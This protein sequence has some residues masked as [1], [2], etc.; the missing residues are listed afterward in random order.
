MV[1]REANE[2]KGGAEWSLHDNVIA[3]RSHSI[4]IGSGQ[5][6][7]ARRLLII[8][9]RLDFVGKLRVRCEGTEE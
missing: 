3:T 4:D 5:V 2:D 6:R 1:Y 7:S 8:A 9:R